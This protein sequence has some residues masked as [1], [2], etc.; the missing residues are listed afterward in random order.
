MKKYIFSFVAILTLLVVTACGSNKL[1]GSWEGATT[2]GIKTT[3]TFD[4]KDKVTYKNEYAFNSTGTYKIKDDKVTIDLDI[5]SSPIEYKFEVKN[6]KLNL[7]ATN[8][9]SANY[10]GMVK[11]K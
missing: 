1:K 3:I 10:E 7:T 9:Y 5:W 2:D 4:K 11:K 8:G 6:S